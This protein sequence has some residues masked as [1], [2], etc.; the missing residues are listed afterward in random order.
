MTVKT[1]VDTNI[2][3]YAHDVD[4]GRKHKTARDILIELMQSGSGALSPQVLQEFYVTVTRKIP[5]R[6]TKRAAQ[7]LA[8]DV[9]NVGLGKGKAITSTAN[10]L[11]VDRRSLSVRIP[12]RPLKVSMGVRRRR[13][14]ERHIHR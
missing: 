3:V 7:D 13:N 4:G 2:L 5:K 12:N 6:L 11:P 1:F 8:N 10:T 9:S 14:E